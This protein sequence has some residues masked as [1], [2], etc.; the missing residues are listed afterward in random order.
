MAAEIK[1]IVSKEDVFDKLDIR[2]GRV[3]AVELSPDTIKRSYVIRVDFGRFGVKTSVARLT[4]HAPE[5]LTGKLVFGVLNFE[6]K[7]VGSTLSEFLCLG[8]QVPKAES[9]EAM[10]VTPLGE[11]K[12]GS[13]LF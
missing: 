9:G 1:P 3:L 8:V 6:S 11:A 13:K 12:I 7:M 10:I 5:E 4:T 2:L